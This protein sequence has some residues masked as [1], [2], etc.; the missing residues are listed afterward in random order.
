[1]EKR[2]HGALALP[3]QL[4]MY[5]GLIILTVVI[6]LSFS[7]TVVRTNA[8]INKIS[9]GDT[10]LF[11]MLESNLLSPSCAPASG[12]PLKYVL[13][14]GLSAVF[15]PNPV[16]INYNGV[17]EKID[18]GKC[19][20]A[21]LKSVN[22]EKYDFY[23]TYGGT[24]YYGVLSVGYDI[25]KPKRTEKIYLSVPSSAATPGIAEAVLNANLDGDV[26]AICPEDE[27]THFCTPA[28]YCLMGKN[29]CDSNYACGGATCCC[30]G[31]PPK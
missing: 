24:D 22:L 25:Y 13:S 2:R 11:T 5:V 6:M 1:M 19:V 18:V 31:K 10:V 30:Y 14:T 3:I 21:F 8:N 26:D 12:I 23:A 27:G 9:H 20:K 4:V 7:T 28:I 15:P 29:I 17:T 16:E